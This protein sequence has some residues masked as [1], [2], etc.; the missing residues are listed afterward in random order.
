MKRQVIGSKTKISLDV[1]WK[2]LSPDSVKKSVEDKTTLDYLFRENF[3][4]GSKECLW[5]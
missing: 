1:R 3:L 4:P 5:G 2:V